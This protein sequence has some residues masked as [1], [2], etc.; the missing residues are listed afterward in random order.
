MSLGERF[1]QVLDAARVGEEWAIAA[2]YRDLQPRVVTFLRHRCRNEAEDV[3]QETWMDVA[4]ALGSFEGGEDEFRKLVFVIAKRRSI[5]HARRSSIRPSDPV[6]N[7]VMALHQLGDAEEDA[8]ERLSADEAV[9][10]VSQLLPP[11]QAE[12]VLLRVLGGF[13][14]EEVAA[15]LGRRPGTIRSLQHRALRRLAAA[16]PSVNATETL[17]KAM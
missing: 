6:P 13:S 7:E 2:L 16:F 8:L 3:A 12:I 5:D 1:P 17:R 11:E 9:S 10:I 4:R 14:S 15:M